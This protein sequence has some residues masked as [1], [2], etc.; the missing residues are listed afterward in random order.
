[1]HDSKTDSLANTTNI[2]TIESKHFHKLTP[3][4]QDTNTHY[5]N[6]VM[7]N[8][9][10]INTVE[11][12]LNFNELTPTGKTEN[13]VFLN[14]QHFNN[15]S[16]Q[17]NLNNKLRPYTNIAGKEAKP[18][19]APRFI[20]PL[21]DNKIPEELLID[22]RSNLDKLKS[23]LATFQQIY[24]QET[25]EDICATC[26]RDCA[27]SDLDHKT[28][29]SIC[30]Q[31]YKKLIEHYKATKKL[32]YGEAKQINEILQDIG[33]M[34]DNIAKYQYHDK[35]HKQILNCYP[36]MHTQMQE[37]QFKAKKLPYIQVLIN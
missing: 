3:K 14:S 31:L 9:T 29:T 23:I 2:G 25:Y 10:N 36:V 8:I 6:M 21:K 37:Q 18:P 32:S 34:T 27:I 17:D 24:P 5:I 4:D 30:F 15:N 20:F 35:R 7:D 19:K 33:V 22:N 13:Y 28:N 11:S 12:E 16:D 26:Q 1:M